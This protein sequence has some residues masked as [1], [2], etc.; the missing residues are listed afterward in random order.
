[1]TRFWLQIGLVGLAAGLCSALLF[2][3]VIS[4][5]ALSLLLC[6]LA[7]LP[8]LIAAMGWSHWAS[9]VAVVVAATALALAIDPRFAIGFP[10]SVGLPAWWLGYLALLARPVGPAGELE[11]YPVG[12][13]V[14]WAVVLSALV[15]LIGLAPLGSTQEAIQQ[16]LR[17]AF[18]HMLRLQLAIPP[19]GPLVVPGVDDPNRLIDMLVR[20]LPP[21]TAV[22][23]TIMQLINL[24]LAG[25]VV[26]ISGQLRRPWPDIAATRLPPTAMLALTI[27][28]AVSFVPGLLG[29]AA[30]L[31]AASLL[32]AYAALGFAVMHGITRHLHGRTAVLIGLYM[33][34]VL[35][36]WSG[37]PILVMAMLGMVDGVVDLRRRVAASRGPPPVPP[38]ERT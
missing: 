21:A 11:W 5:S 26:K 2:A 12:R 3:S 6:F 28:F 18:E 8:I 34:F 35:L 25:R 15:T 17:T 37:W 1:M 9:L 33:G 30:A 27:A 31:P 19:E 38:P 20:A 36:G 16:A 23:T 32:V 4:G 13:L 29:M 7:P 14:L 10:L 24:W 22:L